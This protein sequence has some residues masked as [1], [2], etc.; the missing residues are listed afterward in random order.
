[1]S[2]LR[3]QVGDASSM[4]ALLGLVQPIEGVVDMAKRFMYVSVG[5]L[6]LVVAYQVGARDARADWGNFGQISG[7]TPGSS[8]Q[9]DFLFVSSAGEAWMREYA[10]WIR[11]ADLDLPVPASDVKFLEGM[12][13]GDSYVLVTNDDSIWVWFS[14]EWEPSDPLPGGPVSLDEQSWGK[15]KAGF[16]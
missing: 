8:T 16:R 13:Q 15:T 6:C 2:C 4:V 11:R 3:V 1:M 5:V 10:G 14:G 12:G 9:Q 7:V